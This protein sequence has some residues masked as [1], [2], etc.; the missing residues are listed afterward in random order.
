VGRASA[1]VDYNAVLGHQLRA[2]DPNQG[3]YTLEL[4]SSGRIGAT[5]VAAVFHHVSRHLS[6]RAKT[7]PID[8]N[9]FGARVL[10]RADVSGTSM[11]VEAMVASVIKH[12]YVDYR[13]TGDANAVVRRPLSR[14]VGVFMDGAV[15][16]FGVDPAVAGRDSQVGGLVEAG[17]RLNGRGGAVELFAGFENRVDADPLDRQSHHW[18]LA[19]FRFASPLTK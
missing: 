6:D 15:D 9:T 3:N 17:V 4:S 13:W 1:R 5:E 14:H 2:F 11:A 10:R 12:D 7:E 19:G 18:G 8:W 16:I